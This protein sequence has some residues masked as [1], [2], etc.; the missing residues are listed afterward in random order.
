MNTKK[1]TDINIG[2]DTSKSTLD[3][4]ILPSHQ[5]FHVNNSTAGIARAIA[6]IKKL[7]P[8]RI[9]I[10]ATGRMEKNFVQACVEARLPVVVINP[11][12]MRRFACACGITAKTDAL[13]AKVIALFAARIK[14]QIRPINDKMS[15]SINDLLVRRQQLS[16]MCTMEK[17]RLSIMPEALQDSIK[18]TLRHLLQEQ[19]MIE[20]CLDKA[21]KGNTQW[22]EICQVLN[23]IPGVGEITVYTMLGQLPELGDLNPKQI[24]ALVGVAPM[25]RDSGSHKG[26]RRIR[27]GRHGVRKVLYMATLSAVRCNPIIK[28][29]Y[30]KLRQSGK[31]FK[32]AMIAC[33]RKL[34]VIMNAMVRDRLC[35]QQ[36]SI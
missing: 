30:Q 12:A 20:Q 35:W 36:A 11:L 29:H 8:T 13:D 23:S 25:N 32:V 31:Y 24:A 2:V 9:V 3:F 14:P 5:A 4:H 22:N 10:E 1:T 34:I 15:Q 21:I 18:N 26:Q 16:D 17:N 33:M 28:A 27:G 19:K 6:R 7:N